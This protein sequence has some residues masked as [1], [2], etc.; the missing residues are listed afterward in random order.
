MKIREYLSTLST[1]VIPDNIVHELSHRLSNEHLKQFG[2]RPQK[3]P[4]KVA[5]SPYEQMTNE[6]PESFL[7]QVFNKILDAYLNEIQ[8]G[9]K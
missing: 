1:D 6:Y 3:S 2:E 7:D 4:E 9:R 5:Y 8:N